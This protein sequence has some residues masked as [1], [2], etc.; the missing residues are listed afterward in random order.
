[1]EEEGQ[2]PG[3]PIPGPADVGQ[4]AEYDEDAAAETKSITALSHVSDADDASADDVFG[5]GMMHG[6]PR[7]PTLI[8]WKEGGETVFVTGSWSNWEVKLKLFWK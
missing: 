2:D 3:S 1:V 5:L 4:G 7:V 8:E 6:L